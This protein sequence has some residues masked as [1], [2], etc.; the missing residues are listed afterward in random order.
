[1]LKAR[2]DNSDENENAAST[3]KG[4]MSH[5]QVMLWM[6][7][8]QERNLGARDWEKRWD[9]AGASCFSYRCIPVK[10]TTSFYES[11][12]IFSHWIVFLPQRSAIF[13]TDLSSIGKCFLKLVCFYLP[14]IS[15]FKVVKYSLLMSVWRDSFWRHSLLCD[16]FHEGRNFKQYE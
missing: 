1:M 7:P 11:T 14:C 8:H 12:S 6:W 9:K 16:S 13:F 4:G 15:L 2:R 5:Q 10:W 3:L